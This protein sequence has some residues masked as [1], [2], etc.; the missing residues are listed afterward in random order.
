M[1]SK[2][3][4]NANFLSTLLSVYRTSVET[5]SADEDTI[6]AKDVDRR[7]FD[8][9]TIIRYESGLSP[10]LFSVS[11]KVSIIDG[12]NFD[13]N[14]VIEEPDQLIDGSD[15][16]LIRNANGSNGS[17]ISRGIATGRSGLRTPTR[18]TLSGVTQSVI[19]GTFK[20]ASMDNFVLVKIPYSKKLSLEIFIPKSTL[21]SEDHTPR[22][23]RYRNQ[24][25]SEKLSYQ[26]ILSAISQVKPMKLRIKMPKVNLSSVGR[27]KD[28]LASDEIKINNI[29]DPALA[30]LSETSNA[31][32]I[33]VGDINYINQFNFP[34]GARPTPDAKLNDAKMSGD[35]KDQGLQKEHR[36]EGRRYSSTGPYRVYSGGVR[37][38]IGGG[39]PLA[40]DDNTDKKESDKYIPITIHAPFLFLVRD[41][42]TGHNLFLGKLIN[43]FN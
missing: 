12:V 7:C 14:L 17:F 4:I 40:S 30:E 39:I 38:D 1:E 6:L 21:R 35:D 2:N 42:V 36:S 18:R 33:S 25:M 9:Q 10:N 26:S 37:R 43:P 29:F 15:Y 5:R 8:A 20:V 22:T 34:T 41:E 32:G 31:F 28:I 3:S 23:D 13:D 27:F 11:N 16:Y 24:S 19:K